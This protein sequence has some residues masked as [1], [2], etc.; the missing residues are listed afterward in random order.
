MMPA[1][2]PR[3]FILIPQ[4]LTSDRLNN[5]GLRRHYVMALPP[6]MTHPILSAGSPGIRVSGYAGMR[7]RGNA[8]LSQRELT[9]VLTTMTTV[10]LPTPPPTRQLKNSDVRAAEEFGGGSGGGAPGLGGVDTCRDHGLEF[11]VAVR[12]RERPAPIRCRRRSKRCCWN[13]AGRARIGVRAG[14]STSWPYDLS[15]DHKRARRLVV[16][17]APQAAQF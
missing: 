15:G 3:R 12:E 2:N 1:S 10:G 16:V 14:W 7:K 5:G 8:T 17:D 11:E 6:L 9:T 13:C 4:C